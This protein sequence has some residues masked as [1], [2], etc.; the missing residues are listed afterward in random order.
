[1]LQDYDENYPVNS[2]VNSNPG[3]TLVCGQ[4]T[5]LLGLF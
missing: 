1:M 3:K 4:N 2:V 5:A